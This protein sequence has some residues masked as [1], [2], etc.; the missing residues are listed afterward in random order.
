ME[1]VSADSLH[2]RNGRN[3]GILGLAALADESENKFVVDRVIAQKGFEDSPD[4][5]REMYLVKWEGYPDEE[6]TVSVLYN[7]ATI[8]DLW[9]SFSAY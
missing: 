2:E 4:G 7:G 9:Y 3:S 6:C 1:A 5:K 8:S